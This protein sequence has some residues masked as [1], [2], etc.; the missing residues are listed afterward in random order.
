MEQMKVKKQKDR[1]DDVKGIL[2]FTSARLRIIAHTLAKIFLHTA[3]A[4]TD[5]HPFKTKQNP[6]LF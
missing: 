1:I 4:H 5:P 2:N 3:Q 6:N